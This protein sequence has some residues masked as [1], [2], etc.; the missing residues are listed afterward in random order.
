MIRKGDTLV[1]P[2]TGEHVTFLETAADTGGDYV[3]IEVAVDP[4]GF[5]AAAH[6]HP[7]QSERFEIVAGEAEF[8]IGRKTVT[9]RPGDVV[10]VGNSIS[11]P[12]TELA[13]P[14]GYVQAVDVRSDGEHL[15]R[16][17]PRADR[18]RVFA[19]GAASET[20]TVVAGGEQLAQPSESSVSQLL[21]RNVW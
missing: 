11:D 13:Q 7:Y 20:V 14:P 8:T 21:N 4:G 6:V 1:N 9:A 10:V 15:E 2:V 16:I 12:V 17:A 5:V 3:L 19:V 18:L